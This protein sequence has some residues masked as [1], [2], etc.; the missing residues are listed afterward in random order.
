[1]AAAVLASLLLAVAAATGASASTAGPPAASVATIEKALGIKSVPAEIVFLIDL[2]DSMEQGGLYAQVQRDL[3]AYL[4][5]LAAQA[6]QD[7]VTVITFGRPGTAQ[8]VYTGPPTPAIG[9]P[10][11]ADLGSTDFGPAFALAI[12]Q[13]G[14]APTGTR[15]GGVVLMSDGELHAPT[16]S[17]YQT[18]QSPGWQELRT[19]AAALPIKVTGYSLPLTTNPAHVA[20]QRHALSTVFASLQTLPSGTTDLTAALNEAGRDILNQE[21]ADAAA[22]DSGRGV[23]TTWSGLPASGMPLDLR[24]AGHLDVR[25]TI[26]ALTKR[27]PLYLTN[28]GVQSPGLSLTVDGPLPAEQMLAPGHSVTLAIRLTWPGNT[29]GFSFSGGSRTVSSHLVLTGTVGSTFAPTLASAF[30][31][32]S[33]SA[34][35]LDG[36]P[37]ATLTAAV[38]T[39]GVLLFAL[40]LLAVVVVAIGAVLYRARLSGTLTLT[41]WEYNSGPLPLGPWP[42]TSAETL[43]LI[44][45]PGRI[46]V[47]GSV[48]GHAMRLNLSLAGKPPGAVHLEPGGRTMAVGI[49]IV[50]H[51]KR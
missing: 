48:F 15:I 11:V 47:R 14:Q 43:D 20:D 46:A 12:S 21:V 31:D 40:L 28:L 33:F 10:P 30:A 26:T 7:Q 4:A 5:T 51:R 23:R 36:T 45:I 1:M 50:H 16:D 35:G 24:S 38:A 6:P 25:V 9:L 34:G 18:Y 29:R 39:T 8:I 32:T 41:T 2:S 17:Q 37:S 19:R 42:R 22:P 13:L 44:G 3:P 49:D 27:I